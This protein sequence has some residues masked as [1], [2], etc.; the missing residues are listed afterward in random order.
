MV[1]FN[2]LSQL[3]Q[4]TPYHDDAGPLYFCVIGRDYRNARLND[5]VTLLDKS[6]SQMLKNILSVFYWLYQSPL[7]MTNVLGVKVQNFSW[8][9]FYMV[10]VACLSCSMWKTFPLS[11][12]RTDI[13]QCVSSTTPRVEVLGCQAS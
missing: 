5:T 9:Q 8:N 10:H 1:F 3:K 2:V 11:G 6:T 13:S 12:A 4:R 7:I